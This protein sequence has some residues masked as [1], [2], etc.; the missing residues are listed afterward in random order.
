MAE[1]CPDPGEEDVSS[2][3]EKRV[4]LFHTFAEF[5]RHVNSLPLNRLRFQNIASHDSLDGY[6]VGGKVVSIKSE[7]YSQGHDSLVFLEEEDA[8]K[9]PFQIMMRVSGELVELLPT[10]NTDFAVFVAG[11]RLEDDD[12]DFSQDT[13]VLAVAPL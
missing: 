12:V 3:S 10:L 8:E 7:S 9:D 6:Y 13:G 5:K 2:A 11:A 4:E 1:C